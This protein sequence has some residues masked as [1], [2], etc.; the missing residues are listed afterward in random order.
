MIEGAR[1]ADQWVQD[2][3]VWDEIPPSKAAERRSTFSE[4]E[5]LVAKPNVIFSADVPEALL[6]AFVQYV[7]DFDSA[8]PGCHFSIVANTDLATQDMEPMFRDLERH[9]PF[10]SL[11]VSPKELL[12]QVC[13]FLS[14]EK[15]I[16]CG[17]E[18]SCKHCELTVESPHGPGIPGCV[19]RAQQLISLVRSPSIPER[20]TRS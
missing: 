10:S 7:R 15:E 16:A 12:Y 6:G 4:G 8:N 17:E 19:M 18:H 14:D 5:S 1:P 13:Q 9:K 20:A 11:Q 3:K 2:G